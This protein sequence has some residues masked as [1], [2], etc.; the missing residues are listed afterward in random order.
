MDTYDLMRR[1]A[2]SWGLLA[3]VL[4][5]L[6]VVLRSINPARGREM[7]EAAAIPLDDRSPRDFAKAAQ[8][9][10]QSAREG[11]EA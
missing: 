10:G 8:G 4:F 11:D 3:M 6:G 2:D 5:F 1:F 9:P 7:R